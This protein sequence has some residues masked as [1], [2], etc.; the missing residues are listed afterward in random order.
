MKIVLFY[1]GVNVSNI[2]NIEEQRNG[3]IIGK[4]SKVVTD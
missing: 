1:L 4:A 2:S 3:K